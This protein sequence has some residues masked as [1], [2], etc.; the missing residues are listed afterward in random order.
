[1]LNNKLDLRFNW[2]SDELTFNASDNAATPDSPMQFPMKLER[3]KNSFKKKLTPK[4][5]TVS[6]ELTFNASDNDVTPGSQTL[7]S[8]RIWCKNTKENAIKKLT[9]KDSV[10][11]EMN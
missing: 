10:Q 4:S 3:K 6:V 5:K 9:P 11:W 7:H 2:V 8:K 1:M